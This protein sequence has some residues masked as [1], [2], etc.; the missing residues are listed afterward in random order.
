MPHVLVTGGAGYFGG[1]LKRHLLR[2]RYHVT[3]IDRAPDATRHSCLTKRTGDLRDPWLLNSAFRRARYDAVFHCGAVVPRGCCDEEDLWTSNVNATRMIAKACREWEVPKLIFASTSCLWGGTAHAICEDD[4]PAPV[5]LYGKSKLAAEHILCEFSVFIDVVILRSPAIIDRVSGGLLAILFDLIRDGRTIWTPGNADNLCQV[6][7]AEDLV[8][9]FM[10]AMRPGVSD[11]FH[12]A[13]PGAKSVRELL[14]AVID[15]ARSESMIRGLHERSART[16]LQVGSRFGIPSL[17][18]YE[19]HMLLDDSFLDTAKAR[20]RLGWRASLT[21]EQIL[22]QAFRQSASR[23]AENTKRYGIRWFRPTPLG[24]A[25]R[26][27]W[28]S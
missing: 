4:T 12:V 19:S 28:V 3:S 18:P 8:R 26:L 20:E 16:A 25:R 9:A 27:K 2:H 5:D 6:V 24:L 7:S 11:I 10:A 15:A 14:L 23:S 17:S 21:C 22:V 1:I 13:D